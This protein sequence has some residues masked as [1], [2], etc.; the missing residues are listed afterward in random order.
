MA[1][2][3][4]WS[5]SIYYELSLGLS[6]PES[7]IWK[8]EYQSFKNYETCGNGVFPHSSAGKESAFSAGDPGLITGS[9]R[10]AGESIAYPLQYSWASLVAQ[11]VENLPAMWETW[12]NPCVRKILG[13]R[14]RLS[15]S[16][17]WPG[18]FH[19]L[20]SHNWMTFIFTLSFTRWMAKTQNAL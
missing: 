5:H 2:E 19:G 4:L 14:E 9:G 15:T 8:L 3:A 11:L 12:F 7:R 17:F 13:K 18:E 20:Y 16:V 6:N 10:S 1:S